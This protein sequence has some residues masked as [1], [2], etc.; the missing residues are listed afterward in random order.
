MICPK[1]MDFGFNGPFTNLSSN[2]NVQQVHLA[3]F[4]AS[5]PLPDEKTSDT[6]IESGSSGRDE[7]DDDDVDAAFR[8]YMSPARVLRRMSGIEAPG[9]QGIPALAPPPTGGEQRCSLSYSL[10]FGLL[11]RRR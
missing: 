9:I 10:A 3:H 2:S 4:H 7:G 8:E 1:I 11:R 5:L 6:E